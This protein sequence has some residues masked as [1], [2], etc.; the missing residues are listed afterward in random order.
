M[1]EKSFEEGFY[2]DFPLQTKALQTFETHMEIESLVA[3]I[4]FRE[5]IKQKL[6]AR[7]ELLAKEGLTRPSELE[8]VIEQFSVELKQ[9]EQ[10]FR[11]SSEDL[12]QGVESLPLRQVL[13]KTF[14][15]SFDENFSFSQ[16]ESQ[17]FLP[18]Q[19]LAAKNFSDL[20]AYFFILAGQDLQSG[21]RLEI[22]KDLHVD[23]NRADQEQIQ[24]SFGGSIAKKTFA[25]GSFE[26]IVSGTGSWKKNNALFHKIKVHKTLTG[27]IEFNGKSLPVKVKMTQWIQSHPL[28][29]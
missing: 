18:Y 4:P 26:G 8:F 19:G 14:R 2:L 13:N 15:F 9:A 20:F 23:I 1:S 25:N 22:S 24:A 3:E 11:F 16:E 17:D 29:F 6:L 10:S 7:A 5:E 21:K 28:L 27:L 12:E